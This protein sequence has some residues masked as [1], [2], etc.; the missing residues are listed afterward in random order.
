[1]RHLLNRRQLGALALLAAGGA[2]AQSRRIVAVGGAITETLYRLGAQAELVGVDT[3]SLYPAEAQ[4]LPSVGYARALSAEGLLALRPNLILASGEAG[5]P[6]VLRQLEAARLPLHL[7]DAGH[8]LAGVAERTRRIGTL[9]G[10]AA[11]G[12]ALAAQIEADTAT[13]QRRIGAAHKPAPRV[14]FVLAH[15][16][17]SLRLGGQ[18]TAAHAMLQ[19][20]GGANAFGEVEGFKPLNAEAA[21]AARP[22]V[23]LTTT[24]GLEAVG[25]VAG[26]LALPGLAGTPAGRT[27]RV[28]ALDALLMLGFGPR[29]PVA[30]AELADALGTV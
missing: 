4:K 25:G 15:S 9:V 19:L 1:M 2:Q 6:A 29:L 22:E 10:R 5:P 3:T 24:Q 21:L 12:N 23:L 27:R 17:A 11:A 8:S 14:L 30:L 26:L 18:G 28:V 13:V 7:L 16:P 20:A